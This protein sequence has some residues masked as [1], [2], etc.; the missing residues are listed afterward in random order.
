VWFFVELDGELLRGIPRFFEYVEIPSPPADMMLPVPV[1]MVQADQFVFVDLAA[2]EHLI[3][4]GCTGSGKSV[5]VR[6]FIAYMS[7]YFDSERV[8]FCLGDF[9]DGQEFKLF[10]GG[11]YQHFIRSEEK[12]I[13]L[14]DYLEA[15]KDRRAAL[16]DDTEF[17]NIYQ[18]NDA[19]P[20]KMQPSIIVVIDEY[21]QFQLLAGRSALDRM[22][23]L[24]AQIRSSAMH[25]VIA[26][27]R[28]DA[29]LLDG[30]KFNIPTR[31]TFSFVSP[32]D[33][34]VVLPEGLSLFDGPTGCKGRGQFLYSDRHFEF[35]SAYI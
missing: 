22:R 32:I 30:I 33:Y 19:F 18:F 35:Q 9:K 23:I 26:T 16:L 25:L 7:K 6:Q 11:Q 10:K 34:D 3:V 27:Q 2:N 4:A 1:G 29:K 14:L 24:A 12:I 28:P 15:E 5:F 17:Y 31:C 8:Q 13:E 20:E 21:A